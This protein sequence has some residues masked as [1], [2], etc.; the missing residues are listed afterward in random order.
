MLLDVFAV[1][2]NNCNGHAVYRSTIQPRAHRPPS[3]AL[4]QRIHF[5]PAQFSAQFFKLALVLF[6]PRVGARRR[7]CHWGRADVPGQVWDGA[8]PC[9]LNV[10]ATAICSCT[11]IHPPCPCPAPVHVAVPLA[12]C[13]PMLMRA[14]PSVLH[15]LI[16]YHAIVSERLCHHMLLCL[17]TEPQCLPLC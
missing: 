4:P 9:P 17:R 1:K 11:P 2:P 10:T 6:L 15:P 16:C 12:A 8:F 13:V 5:F 14:P 7:G 3:I